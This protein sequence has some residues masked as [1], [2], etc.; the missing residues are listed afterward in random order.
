VAQ[1]VWQKKRQQIVL[2]AAIDVC[3]K[4]R[5]DMQN[6]L[7]LLPALACPVGMGLLMWLMMRM[8]KEQR[9]S[10]AVEE[11][12]QVDAPQAMMSPSSP[13]G[14]IWECVQMCLNWKV[15]AGLVVV[16]VLVGVAA[17]QFFWGAIPLLLVLACPLSMMVM[18]LSMRRTRS[19]SGN[20]ATSC[21]ACEPT[22]AG[23]SQ[24]LEPPDREHSSTVKW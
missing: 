2:N 16:A 14:A 1:L 12:R 8:G 18:V 5:D 11:R 22:A 23:S 7:S 4:G 13:L 17:P 24:A 3:K 9:P 6:L 15:L 19:T 20:G 10:D 21:S